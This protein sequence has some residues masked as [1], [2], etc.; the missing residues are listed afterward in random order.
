MNI[1]GDN[2]IKFLLGVIVLIANWF[3]FKK[4]GREGWEG[5]V[6]IYNLYVYCEELYGNGWKF[7]LILVPLYNI[8]FII[9]MNIDIAQ[10]FNKSS[11]FA[12]GMLVFPYIFDMILGF[13]DAQYRDGSKANNSEDILSNVFSKAGDAVNSVRKDDQALD[14]I[15]QLKKMMEEGTITEE[16]YKAKKEELLKRL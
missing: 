13:S 12:L 15:N 2:M 16:E 11:G 4:M 9:K 1:E 14:K 5:I 7:L 10:A 6:P 8:Y 3:I